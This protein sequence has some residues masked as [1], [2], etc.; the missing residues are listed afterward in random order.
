MPV[1][2][3]M[4]A[5]YRKHNDGSHSS[6]KYHKLDGTAIRAILKRE[7]AKE[8]LILQNQ[9]ELEPKMENAR[10]ASRAGCAKDDPQYL[11]DDGQGCLRLIS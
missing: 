3:T 6:S 5:T 8:I 7:A 10:I 1:N 9:R 11:P 2:S 4:K